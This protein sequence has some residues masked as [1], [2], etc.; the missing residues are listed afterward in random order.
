MPEDADKP[1][2]AFRPK[3]KVLIV[4]HI[5]FSIVLAALVIHNHVKNESRFKELGEKLERCE[6]IRD[7]ASKMTA[8]NPTP[9]PRAAEGLQL[10][11][12][13]SPQE[14]ETIRI[15][16]TTKTTT[17]ANFI[18]A[19]ENTTDASFEGFIRETGLRGQGKENSSNDSDLQNNI[20]SNESSP[21][22]H[23]KGPE[24]NLSRGWYTGSEVD[25]RSCL[26]LLKSVLMN[27]SQ[28]I[29]NDL[30]GPQ[31]PPGKRG[32]QGLVG[33]QGEQGERGK[34]GLSH[35]GGKQDRG[36]S[37]TML[38]PPLFLETQLIYISREGVSPEMTCNTTANPSADITWY[39]DDVMLTSK[40][41]Q[42]SQ[43][44]T[45]SQIPRR[46]QMLCPSKVPHPI[47]QSI[48][49]IMEARGSDTGT[50]TC[51]ARNMMGARDR[52]VVLRV[53]V[54]PRL[55]SFLG[56]PLTIVENTTAVVPCATTG[57]PTPVISWTKI[58]NSMDVSRSSYDS[59]ALTIEDVQYSD[60]GTYVCSATNIAGRVNGTVTIIVQVAPRI[61]DQ[62]KA[63]EFGYHPAAKKLQ[64]R[65]FGFPPPNVTWSGP[66]LSHSK[67][68]VNQSDGSLVIMRTEFRDS[69]EYK[70]IVKNAVGEVVVRTFLVVSQG[71]KPMFYATPDRPWLAIERS[72][73]LPL[74][75]GAMGVP[76]PIVEW[77]HNGSL[78]KSGVGGTKNTK[79]ITLSWRGLEGNYS[80]RASNIFGAVSKSI[81]IEHSRGL[82]TSIIL[83]K[84]NHLR[85]LREFLRPVLTSQESSRWS[86]CW[87]ASNNGWSNF[88]RNCNNKGPTVTIVR[89]GTYVFGGY[90]DVSWRNRPYRWNNNNQL[91]RSSRKSFL[92]SLYS[93]RGFH[94]LKLPVMDYSYA[95]YD[96]GS[97]PTFGS[98]RDLYISSRSG[99][100]SVG[101]YKPPPGCRKGND[102]SYFAGASSFTPDEVEVF[103]EH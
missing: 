22:L 27:E 39:R 30:R 20:T 66:A 45:E 73:T 41:Y 55:T 101:S 100:T 21:E 1:R 28:R 15:R 43:S 90:T 9:T 7:S 48:L 6:A 78:I 87:R 53:Q 51:R 76:S 40:R 79:T 32:P 31:G 2:A 16:A 49:V 98:G 29:C 70:A 103:Y 60:S 56:M 67:P 97:G 93:T 11:L 12:R 35:D 59:R 38:A 80:C 61:K 25:P 57:F 88:H 3:R 14:N 19:R 42:I 95:V 10:M 13:R 86:R 102:C 18:K 74:T 89:V 75:C 83:S 81:Y 84:R 62:P 65:V 92:F 37:G 64:L 91:Y 34:P 24:R 85:A 94:P 99:S 44:V 71:V 36:C 54:I 50:Y 33:P 72:K 52:H 96:A 4:C 77:Y 68:R 26:E 17:R 5:V 47:T 46:I 69:G 82:E 58:G 63:I 23:A 8:S